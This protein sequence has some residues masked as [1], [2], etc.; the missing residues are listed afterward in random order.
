MVIPFLH[1]LIANFNSHFPCVVVELVFPASVFHS[2]LHPDDEKLL[3]AYGNSKLS[4]LANI[5]GE[6]NR[7]TFDRVTYSPLAIINKEEL[8]GE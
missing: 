2:A 1:T 5:Y 6:K 8:L 4:T 7:V 3:K